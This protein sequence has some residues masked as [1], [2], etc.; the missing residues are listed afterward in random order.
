M[1]VDPA[2]LASL[3]AAVGTPHVVTDPEQLRVYD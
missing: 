1:A 2:L 3:E